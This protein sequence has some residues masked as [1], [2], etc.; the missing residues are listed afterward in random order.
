L[1]GL[2]LVDVVRWHPSQEPLVGTNSLCE[3]T[4]ESPS[5]P[6]VI[7]NVRGADGDD[8]HIGRKDEESPRSPAGV[9][10]FFVGE[11]VGE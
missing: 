10:A 5:K 11:G 2:R 4:K 1:T 6:A 3:R 7:L 8:V 9:I